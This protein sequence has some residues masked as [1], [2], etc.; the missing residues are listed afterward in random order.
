MHLPRC[1]VSVRNLLQVFRF[2]YLQNFPY[3]LSSAANSLLDTTHTHTLCPITSTG[4]VRCYK[5]LS[6]YSCGKHP[7]T[8]SHFLTLCMIDICAT[9][10]TLS[11]HSRLTHSKAKYSLPQFK[12]TSPWT[13]SATEMCDRA[14]VGTRMSLLRKWAIGLWC[15]HYPPSLLTLRQHG[16]LPTRTAHQTSSSLITFA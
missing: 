13:H 8:Q 6:H 3:T 10:S 5:L 14:L 15:A 11:L 2:L 12:W 9:Q 7:K 4:A 1:S 16:L